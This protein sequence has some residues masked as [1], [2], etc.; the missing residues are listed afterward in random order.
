MRS[1]RPEMNGPR[2]PEA[3]RAKAIAYDRSQ[4][5]R[6]PL[7]WIVALIALFLLVRALTP[8]VGGS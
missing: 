4:T 2:D 7:F 3:P 6:D 8:Q 1:D 5:L